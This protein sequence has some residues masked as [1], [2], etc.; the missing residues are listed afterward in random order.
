MFKKNESGPLIM[1]HSLHFQNSH[2]FTGLSIN[3]V[4]T[5]EGGDRGFR[6]DSTKALGKEDQK[7]YK[8]A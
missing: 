5:L 3:D 7:L 1:A 4:T 6:D 2:S 8:I